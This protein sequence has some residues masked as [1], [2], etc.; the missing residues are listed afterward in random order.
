MKVTISKDVKLLLV[1]MAA[2]LVV[3]IL[4]LS[5]FL[6]SAHIE[7]VVSD[8]IIENQV[9]ET[10]HAA[11]RAEHHILSLRDELVALSYWLQPQEL[12]AENCQEQPEN[13]SIATPLLITNAEGTHHR[14][15]EARRHCTNTDFSTKKRT[16]PQPR[17]PLHNHRHR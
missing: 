17:H 16:R 8:L 9:T 14:N 2:L 15:T 7:Q 10:A 12:T 3:G 4:I 6:S 13:K 5:N 1:L 11:G